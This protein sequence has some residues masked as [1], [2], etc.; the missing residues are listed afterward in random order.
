MDG[1]KM[2][3]AAGVAILAVVILVFSTSQ[4]RDLFSATTCSTGRITYLR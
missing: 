3:T 4:C 1:G 2:W